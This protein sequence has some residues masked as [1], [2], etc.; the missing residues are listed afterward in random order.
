MKTYIAINIKYLIHR[1]NW[2]QLAFA[3]QFDVSRAM[4]SHYVLGKNTP[5][6]ETLL[7]IADHFNLSLDELVR[8]EL[9]K[10]T[11]E[12]NEFNYKEVDSSQNHSFANV[13][14]VRI[15]DLERTIK[16]QDRLIQSLE[17]QLGDR[18]NLAI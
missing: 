7:K 8:T 15:S 4:V 5:K 6:I 11:K 16:I 18:G 13:F 10:N 12:N 3:A 1:E 14:S 2:D 17:Q 9:S